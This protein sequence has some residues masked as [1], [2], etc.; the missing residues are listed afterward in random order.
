M[1]HS[2]SVEYS[3][4]ILVA[5]VIAACSG[6]ANDQSSRGL[7]VP[8]ELRYVRTVVRQ[9]TTE[10][11]TWLQLPQRIS[12]DSAS[13]HLFVL[14]WAEQSIMEFTTS[15][16]FV[17]SFGHKGEGPGELKNVQAYALG[18]HHLTAL[19]MGGGKLE[20]FD[21]SSRAAQRTIRLQRLMLD[22]TAIDDTI[23]AVLPGPD[24]ALFE[25]FNI[26]SGSSLGSFGD[27]GFLGTVCMYCSITYI[28]ND[29]LVVLEPGRIDGRIVRLD[30]SPFEVFAFVELADVLTRWQEQFLGVMREA[31]GRLNNGERGRVPGGKVWFPT[32]GATGDGGFFVIATP[33][34]VGDDPFEIWTL[35]QRGRITARYR[36]DRTWI[37]MYTSSFPTIYTLGSDDQYGIYEYEVP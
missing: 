25:L 4:L 19:D 31:V 14:D 18:R 15:G 10:G 2:K 16:R 9:D 5:V 35:D 20:V 8:T 28:G 12:Y 17:G 24:G 26:T 11:T 32:V 22:I 7:D 13:S 37:G 23:V 34:R 3:S 27:G 30:G 33:A 29:L 21:R 1:I 36:F 6:S